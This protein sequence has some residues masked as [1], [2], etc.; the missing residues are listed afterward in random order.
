MWRVI[1]DNHSAFGV[2]SDLQAF[3]Q[4]IPFNVSLLPLGI[5]LPTQPNYL[6]LSVS[7]LFGIL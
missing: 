5:P 6:M 2:L 7:P 1:Q 4:E 3:L